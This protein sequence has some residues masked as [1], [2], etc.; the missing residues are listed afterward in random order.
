MSFK[1]TYNKVR[2]YSLYLLLG[3]YLVIGF[4]FLFTNIWGDL[5]PKGRFTIGIILILFGSLRFYVGYKRYQNK[6]IRIEAA[7][8][9]KSNAAVE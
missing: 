6:N 8:E 7:K 4:L 3:F 2:L 5:L 1:A 9:T